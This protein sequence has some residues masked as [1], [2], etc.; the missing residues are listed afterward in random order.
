M[1]ASY[2]NS[3]N[4]ESF[5]EVCFSQRNG[6]KLCE[7][8][9]K[10]LCRRVSDD[11]CVC[12]SAYIHTHSS[13][14]WSPFNFKCL[15]C[16]V[17]TG[18]R[19]TQRTDKSTGR[20][21]RPCTSAAPDGLSLTERRVVCIVSVMKCS[22]LSFM[23]LLFCIKRNTGMFTQKAACLFL[24]QQERGRLQTSP[25][26][27]HRSLEWKVFRNRSKEVKRS[28]AH[29]DLAA[30]VIRQCCVH[31]ARVVA[32]DAQCLD[33][34]TV[35]KRSVDRDKVLTFVP[36]SEARS[37]LA[38]SKHSLSEVVVV[39]QKKKKLQVTSLHFFF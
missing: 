24:T 33:V 21:I 13:L 35:G 11:P 22:S 30:D 26:A 36:F 15:T 18:R 6:I 4:W 31:S 10:Y 14:T 39:G 5:E 27:W 17:L 34:G 8:V 19:T 25:H 12:T 7:T 28:F 3:Q 29:A 16:V 1:F 37:M 38:F 9:K 32:T 2:Y 20:I 23:K